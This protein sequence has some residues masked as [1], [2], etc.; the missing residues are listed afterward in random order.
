MQEEFLTRYTLTFVIYAVIGYISEVVYCSVGQRKLVN[1]GFLYGPWLPIYG[2]GGLIVNIFLIPLKA[3]PVLVFIFGVILTSIVEY[4]GSWAL[5]KIFSIKLWDYS[6]H[7]G[8]I[9]GRVCL[10]NSTLFGVM[11]ISLVYIVQPWIDSLIATVPYIFQY[12]TAELL[13]ILFTIDLTLSVIKMNAFKKALREA[14]AKAREIEKKARSYAKEGQS[15]LASEYRERMDR[16]ILESR[17]RFSVMYSRI[18]KA[19]PNATAKRREMREQIERMHKWAEERKNAVAQYKA[20][21]RNMKKEYRRK[22]QD[23][24]RRKGEDEQ[25]S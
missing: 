22:V 6:K 2:C 14:V 23:I 10:L 8:N 13:R 15:A 7:F 24:N 19:F 21:L 20:E 3:Y 18:L 5:E 25:L 17:M 1:R 9:N 11:S 4:I 12:Y 16:E